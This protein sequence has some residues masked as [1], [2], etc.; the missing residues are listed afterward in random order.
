VSG[1][2]T[3]TVDFGAFVELEPG[4]EGLV[5]VSELSDQRVR[6]ASDVVKPG[7]QVNVRV[8]ELDQEGRRISLSLKRAAVGV[9]ASAGMSESGSTPAKKKKRPELRGGLDR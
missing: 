1:T 6:S 2:V 7:Q 5:H 8:L 3:R 4:L 9:P